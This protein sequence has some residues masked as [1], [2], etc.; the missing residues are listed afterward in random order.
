MFMNDNVELRKKMDGLLS[1][2]RFN[3]AFSDALINHVFTQRSVF[4]LKGKLNPNEASVVSA[5]QAQIKN[6]IQNQFSA[7]DRE[8][9]L[10][11]SLK[12]NIKLLQPIAYQST[13]YDKLTSFSPQPING[14]RLVKESYQPFQTFVCGD[15]TTNEKD[16]YLE[17]NPIGFFIE[18]FSYLALK[19]NQVTWMSIT[20]FEIETMKSAIEI[21]DGKV[22]ALGLGLGYFATMAAMKPT[23]NNVIVVE[24]D[25]SVIA[26][27]QQHLQPFL[28]QQNKITIIQADA[29]RYLEGK[30]NADHIFVDIY[31]TAEDGLPLYNALKKIEQNLNRIRWHYWLEDSI[32]GLFRRYLMIY[33]NEQLQGFT[34]T[35][36]QPSNKIEDRV[37]SEIHRIHQSNRIQTFSQL[38]RWLSRVNL[39]DI[40]T[41]IDL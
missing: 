30:I 20:P 10:T 16:N 25:P 4:N 37:L 7:F 32:L 15:V 41:K 13:P 28:P 29:F 8:N 9:L 40:L 17:N 5:I 18:P 26:L 23:V 6:K 1:T 33:L 19:K 11:K 14:W 12:N 36:Y 27:Y 21:V 39:I 35:D 22:I 24:K 38:Q 31:R 3:V 34:N 2:H